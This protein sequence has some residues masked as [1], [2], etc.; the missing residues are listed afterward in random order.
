MGVAAVI[1]DRP[2]QLG[3]GLALPGCLQLSAPG[4]A[5]GDPP[6]ADPINWGLWG[7]SEGLER[8]MGCVGLWENRSRGGGK[9]LQG[10]LCFLGGLYQRDGLDHL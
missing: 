6:A 7:P 1:C 5:P 2:F 10:R 9:I 4:S 8:L 3:S